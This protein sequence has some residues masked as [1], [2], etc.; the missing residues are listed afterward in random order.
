[1]TSLSP[2]ELAQKIGAGLLSF[3]VTAFDAELEFDETRYREHVSY[4][5]GYDV[6]GLFAAGGTGEYFSLSNDEIS[7]V[8]RSAVDEVNGN[9]P[10]LSSA[11]GS[12]V[13]A[14]AQ[15]QIA[16]EAGA[17]GILLFPPY[18]TESSQDGLEAYVSAICQSTSLGVVVYNRANMQFE[19]ST[20]A[21]LADKNPN[22]VGLKDGAGSIDQMTRI[23]SALGDRLAY[24]GGLPTA[25]TFARP[26]L[27]LGVTTYSSAMFNFVPEFALKFY[28]AVRSRDNKY[29]DDAIRDF[30]IPYLEIRDRKK[31]Y[32]VSI[33]K[34]GL[35]ASGRPIGSVRAPL[36]DL[37][38]EETD[39]LGKLIQRAR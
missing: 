31:G 23:R 16:E 9:V 13:N 25:E 34:A 19:A 2:K 18:L 7:Q 11:G 26:Y 21:R 5:N 17:A 20:V 37:T 35:N 28:A 10:V 24:I 22:L 14:I 39:Q 8:V 15:A 27:E 1:M 32:A 12:V 4:L 6:A 38:E 36:T 30:V 29:I 3:P 33:V